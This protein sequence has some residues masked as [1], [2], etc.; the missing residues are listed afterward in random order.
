VY[1]AVHHKSDAT[2]T[3]AAAADDAILARRAF[4]GK[5][6]W[7]Y[8]AS[9][10]GQPCSIT[11]MAQALDA[12]Y[13]SASCNNGTG[14]TFALRASDGAMLWQSSMSGQFSVT[15]GVVCLHITQASPALADLYVLQASTGKQLWQDQPGTSLRQAQVW[16]P[17]NGY[18]YLLDNGTL[19]AR[20]LSDGQPAWNMSFSSN[21]TSQTFETF[22]DPVFL[23]ALNNIVYLQS[24]VVN[25]NTHVAFNRLYALQA[26]TGKQLWSF[27]QDQFNLTW[28]TFSIDA[29]T[30][31]IAIQ[32]LDARH[33]TDIYLLR[34]TDG[35]PQG[36][37]IQSQAANN[38]IITN[39]K[40]YLT[41]VHGDGNNTPF[42]YHLQ[43]FQP[44]SEGNNLLWEFG[45]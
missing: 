15:G 37:I 1:Y 22:S 7:T 6:L 35:K 42:S 3:T 14:R 40:V 13:A 45:A 18:V 28:S 29:T 19:S 12:I 27:Q 10:A 30:N 25:Q 36:S 9:V 11:S 33:P 43:T 5:V 20:R 17:G 21:A 2:T 16:T 32:G 24:S 34:A 8:S 44:G 4:D 23:G 38:V 26:G 41:S 39:D 31:T